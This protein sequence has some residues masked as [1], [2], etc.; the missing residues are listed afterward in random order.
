MTPATPFPGGRLPLPNM[1]TDRSTL[2]QQYISQQS[3]IFQNFAEARGLAAQIDE[4]SRA[5]FEKWEISALPE[6]DGQV[7]LTITNPAGDRVKMIRVHTERASTGKYRVEDL[8]E[9]GS[10]IEALDMYAVD[11]YVYVAMTFAP[12]VGDGLTHILRQAVEE[13]RQSITL[14][15]M[16]IS[17]SSGATY[18]FP[19]TP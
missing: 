19:T 11:I 2:T 6:E 1:E 18:E 9:N 15:E 14:Q 17:W 10:V 5:W 13:F 7:T 4:D 8:H 16:F 12:A 3:A